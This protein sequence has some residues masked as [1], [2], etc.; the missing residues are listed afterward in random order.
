MSGTQV[1]S[2]D[3]PHSPNSQRLLRTA[4]PSQRRSN[5]R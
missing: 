1:K 3:A 4:W 2:H 5:S